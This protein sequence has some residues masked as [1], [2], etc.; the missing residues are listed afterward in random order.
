MDS[1]FM[2][3]LTDGSKPTQDVIK[4]STEQ[5]QHLSNNVWLK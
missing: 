1:G 5:C 4:V 3:N 2:L